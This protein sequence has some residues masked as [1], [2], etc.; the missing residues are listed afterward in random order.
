MISFR[1]L[2][3]I[4][5]FVSFLSLQILFCFVVIRFVVFRFSHLIFCDIVNKFLKFHMNCFLVVFFENRVEGDTGYCVCL[6]G[7]VMIAA[8]TCSDN[9]EC[10]ARVRF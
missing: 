5:C 6:H 7:P 3:Y 9:S 2:V 8:M 10:I 4:F 1:F